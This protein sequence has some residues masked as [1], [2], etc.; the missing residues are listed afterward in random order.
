MEHCQLIKT[1]NNAGRYT[2]DPTGEMLS[3]LK[4]R[5]CRYITIYMTDDIKEV[6]DLSNTEC[7]SQL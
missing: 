6:R 2:Y 4:A 7:I 5:L 1:V 3:Q